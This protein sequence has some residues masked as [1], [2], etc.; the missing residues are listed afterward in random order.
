MTAHLARTSLGTLAI[1]LCALATGAV[2]AFVPVP[3]GLNG[4]DFRLPGVIMAALTCAVAIVL[5]GRLRWPPID[6]LASV[7][8]AEAIALFI[9]GLFSGL[10]GFHLFDSFNLWW[11]GTGSLFIVPPWLAGLVIGGLLRKHHAQKRA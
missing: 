4:R 10:T 8:G 2:F 5:Y 3:A 6:L 7:V 1:F 9:I 11:L